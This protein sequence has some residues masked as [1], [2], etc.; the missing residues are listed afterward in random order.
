MKQ[1]G[2]AMTILLI[3]VL[4]IGIVGYIGFQLSKPLFPPIVDGLIQGKYPP[5]VSPIP[6]FVIDL[7]PDGDEETPS[8]GMNASYD[9]TRTVD[10][11]AIRNAIEQYAIDHEGNYPQTL[12]MLREPYIKIVPKDP[13]TNN[14]YG[15]KLASDTYIL[16]AMLSDGSAF[17]LSTPNISF[18]TVKDGDNI[19]KSDI[20]NIR[21]ALELYASYTSD[22][23]YPTSLSQLTTKHIA[24][25]PKDPTTGENY[26]YKR[27]SPTTYILSAT[28]TDGTL[29][30]VT[31]P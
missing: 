17:N 10:L 15:Y 12:S 2:F 21:S 22:F 7:P 26:S 19:R 14:N 20:H 30:T 6:T 4:V 5:D 18:D 28:L 9:N 11:Y 31:N 13:V 27:T 8:V 29:Y 23:S 24:K 25:L 16:T 3:G 1:K